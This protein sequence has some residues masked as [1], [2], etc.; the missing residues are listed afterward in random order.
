[1]QYEDKRHGLT[2]KRIV[3]VLKCTR[4]YL[5]PILSLN[6]KEN[7]K[8]GLVARMIVAWMVALNSKENCKNPYTYIL[9]L[10]IFLV[11]LA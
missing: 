4:L 6:S 9:Y 7:C 5:L 3:S 8:F 11:F 10:D 1:M 2:Q